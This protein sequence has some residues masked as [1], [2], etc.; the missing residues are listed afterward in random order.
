MYNPATGREEF[1]M[2]STP[3]EVSMGKS[4]HQSIA[5]K[6]KFSNNPGAVRAPPAYRRAPGQ[7]LRP[8]GL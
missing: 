1:I 5:Q 4:V 6:Y 7:G 2:I 8:Q 3:S